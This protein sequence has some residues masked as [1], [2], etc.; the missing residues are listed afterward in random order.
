MYFDNCTTVEEAKKLY[1][2]LAMQYHPDRGGNTKTMQEVNVEYQQLLESF[3]GQTDGDYTY[4]YDQQKEQQVIDKIYELLALHLDGVEINLIGLWVW[5]TGDTKQHRKVLKDAGCK[6][7]SKRECWYW[8]NG[9]KRFQSKGNLSELAK[10]YGV[11]NFVN[12]EMV[13]T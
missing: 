9:K 11:T 7:H 12:Q 4:R 10:K 2:K 5:I 3:D 1:R 8:Q 13:T 6:W